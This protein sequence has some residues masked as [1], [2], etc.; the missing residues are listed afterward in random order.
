M[1][2]NVAVLLADVSLHLHRLEHF[3]EM[4]KPKNIVLLH[5]ANL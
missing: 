5:L 4:F 1:L 3:Q 2:V